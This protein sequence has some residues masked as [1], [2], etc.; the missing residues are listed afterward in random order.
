MVRAMRDHDS[1]NPGRYLGVII[2]LA[3]FFWGVVA[4]FALGAE[5]VPFEF[6]IWDF[7]FLNLP[8]LVGAVSAFAVMVFAFLVAI[9][10]E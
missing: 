7:F 6:T 4:G 3:I 8:G 5:P 10:G 9:S 1:T 2:P